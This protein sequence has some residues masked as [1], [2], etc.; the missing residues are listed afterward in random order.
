MKKEI[1]KAVKLKN[2]TISTTPNTVG[3]GLKDAVFLLENKGFI[4][5]VNGNGTVK[6]QQEIVGRNKKTMVLTLG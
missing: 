3:M 4:V 6:E 5:K 1:L 2:K